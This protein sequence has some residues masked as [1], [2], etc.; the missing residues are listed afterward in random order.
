MAGFQKGVGST[1]AV[2]FD[3]GRTLVTFD[4]PT[5]DLL[6]TMREFRPRIEAALGGPAPQAEAILQ[7]VLLPLEN[8]VGSSSEDEV[9]YMD[10]YRDTWPGFFE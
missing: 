1:Q 10:V 7:N 6:N 2:L 9:R 8:Y 5:E 3:Y 4:Y